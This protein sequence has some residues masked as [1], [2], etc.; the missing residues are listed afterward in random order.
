MTVTYRG[1]GHCDSFVATALTGRRIRGHFPFGFPA[2][3][4]AAGAT[5]F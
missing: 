4:V 1:D 3:S 5:G 2:V